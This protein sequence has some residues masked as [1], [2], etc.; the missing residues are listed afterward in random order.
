[1]TSKQMFFVVSYREPVV[2]AVARV[3]GVEGVLVDQELQDRETAVLEVVSYSKKSDQILC[4]LS[5]RTLNKIFRL[6]FIHFSSDSSRIGS[7]TG[8]QGS[9]SAGSKAGRAR[10]TL[11]DTDDSHGVANPKEVGMYAP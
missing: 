7:G 9:G 11:A 6:I 5:G 4:V 1:M 10:P 8:T 3:V 2:V